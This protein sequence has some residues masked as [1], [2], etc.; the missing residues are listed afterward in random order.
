MEIFLFWLNNSA[1][2]NILY[3][4]PLYLSLSVHCIQIKSNKM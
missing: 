4:Q 2:L 3:Q 1:P